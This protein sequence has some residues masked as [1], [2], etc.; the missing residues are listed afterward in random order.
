[1]TKHR[2]TAT[3]AAAGLSLAAAAP[4]AS[5]AELPLPTDAAYTVADGKIEHTVRIDKVDGPK[6]LPSHTRYETWVSDDRSRTVVTNL[7]TG[8]VQAE[9][10]STPTEIRVYNAQTNTLRIE[11]RKR[12]GGLVENAM[13][14]EQ[15]VQKAYV[16]QGYVRVIG[17]KVV[18]GRRALVTQ[19]AEGKWRSDDRNSVTTAVVDAE[20]F[21]LYERT[22]ELAG[23]HRHAQTFTYE[24]LAETPANVKATLA[25][26]KHP[27]AKVR[28]AKV[29]ARAAQSPRDRAPA[30]GLPAPNDPRRLVPAGQVE[31]TVSVRKV[32][33]SKAVPSHERTERWLTRTH[34]RT[35]VTNLKTGKVRTEI[36]TS[37]AQ[38]SIYDAEK[39][40]LRVMRNGKDA[41]T[42]PYNAV[43]FD[44]AVQKASLEHGYTR[45]IAE[46]Q[47]GGRRALVV[48][49]VPGKWTTDEP[50]SRTVITIDAETFRP[51]ARTTDLS[52]GRFV[53]NDVFEVAELLPAG[54]KTAK[55]R[56]AMAKHPGA[57]RISRG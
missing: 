49:S 5:G 32:E 2:L 36:V 25:M 57:K 55:A 4:A 10:V 28:A 17:E 52:D 53:Q 12:A 26:A 46:K 37:P 9:T 24:V 1:M 30:P 27:R 11:R 29:K 22:T 14:F 16:E 34:S 40:V 45:V 13:A 6:S 43:A 54:T 39:D 56:L 47:V 23:S 33:G 8:R 3:L 38:T 48:E 35:V 15:A 21:A 19:S 50:E 41:Q 42:P 51:L 7:Q 31:H 44:A 20:T 18:N